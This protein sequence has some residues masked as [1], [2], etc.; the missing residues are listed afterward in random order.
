MRKY[1]FWLSWDAPLKQITSVLFISLLVLIISAA[2]LI[3][4]G[5]DGLIGWH[6]FSQKTTVDVIAQTIDVG[7]FSFSFT[8]QLITFKEFVSGGEI[9]ST[10]WF[11]EIAIVLIFMM[12]ALVLALITYFNRFGFIL[13]ATLT[14]FFIIFIHPEMLKLAAINDNWILMG[15]FLLF[16][17]PA[18]YFQ[19]FGKNVSFGIRLVSLVLIMGIFISV[20]IGVSPVKAPLNLLFSYGILAPYMVVLLFIFMVGHEIVN[21]FILAIASGK[22]DRGNNRI[23]H[24]LAITL[25]YLLNVLLSYL[26]ITHVI[27]WN[28]IT[29]NPILL[30]GIA[31]ILGLWGISQ[32]FV[33]YKKVNANQQVWVLLYLAIAII[34]FITINYLLLSLEDPLL[35]IISDFVIFTQLAFGTTFLFYVLYNFISIIEEGHSIKNILY[36]PQNL[37]H[38]SSRVLGVA[39]LT[40]LVLMRDIKYPIWYSLGG[41]YNSIAS[42]FE[43]IKEENIAILFYERG[44]D[45]SKKNH[46]SNY[47]LGTFSMDNDREKAIGYFA[48][49]AERMPTAQSFINKANLESD[50]GNYFEALFTLQKGNKALLKSDEIK[51]NLA[52]QFGKSNMLDSAWHYFST[53]KSLN[54]AQ[55]NALSL[56]LKTNLAMSSYDSS[57]LFS[58]LNEVGVINA[59]ALGYQTQIDS[60]IGGDNMLNAALLNNALVNNLIP[61]SPSAYQSVSQ[62]I[63]STHNSVASEELNYALALYELRNEQITNSLMRLQKL[64]ALGSD[65]QAR[66]FELLGLI[67]LE[68]KAY[69]KAEEYFLLA[70]EFRNP[71]QK[72][73]YTQLA[74]AQSEG[75]FLTDAIQTWE[76]AKEEN[77]ED[78]VKAIVMVQVLSSI[79]NNSDSIINNDIN[80]YLKARYQRLWVDEFAV[81]KSFDRIRD[82]SL[83]NELALELAS[84][85]FGIGNKPASKLFYDQIN[86]KDP[87]ITKAGANLLLEQLLKLNIRLAYGGL[88][89]DI[90]TQINNLIEAGFSFSKEE[91]LEALFFNTNKEELT[92]MDANK[93]ATQNPFFT[94]GV[95]WAAQFYKNSDDYTSYTILQEALNHN[96][97]SRVLLEAYI[98]EAISIGLDQY[99]NTALQHYRSLFPGDL[100]QAFLKKVTLQKEAFDAMAMEEV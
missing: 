78:S 26:Q 22:E 38:V 99:A 54:S 35:K 86:L 74:L 68:K 30:L 83:K 57:F 80:N 5:A 19:A 4:I 75:G 65:K 72:T 98:L 53:V 40:A 60:A 70:N 84:Y 36:Q 95:V 66:Y 56:V 77:K 47:K 37:P 43:D 96:P 31:A 89:S 52:L 63:D 49:A 79:L 97:D 21:G 82:A 69:S 33:L 28:F 58:N 9:P 50:L 23:K 67:F 3:A 17:A 8:E 29:I 39:I 20:V 1:L 6:T 71:G 90:D 42:Y 18:Y 94:E 25:I 13:F 46:K 15:I 76:L 11:K 32:R 41:Y 100:F 12:V 91:R 55:N 92:K 81:K 7:P 73:F 27:S 44:A 87:S 64:S 59:A 51:N 62:I 93:L 88:V 48:L 10:A 45:L 85:Y 16:I 24:F 2:I 61:Y 34:S 14:F